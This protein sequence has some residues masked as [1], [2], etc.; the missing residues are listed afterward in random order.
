MKG[1]LSGLNN[2]SFVESK[3]AFYYQR[4][5]GSICDKELKKIKKC[6]TLL[7]DQQVH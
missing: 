1:E 7:V 3:R 5:Q 4:K 2:K 6:D